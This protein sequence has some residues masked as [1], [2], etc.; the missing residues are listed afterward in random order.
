MKTK[1]TFALIAFSTFIYS[2]EI[3]SIQADRPDQTETPAIVPKGMFQVETGFTFQKD[4][5]NSS[6]FSLPSF[7]ILRIPSEVTFPI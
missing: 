5:E 4:D 3:E 6:A 1:I 2:Q 7:R